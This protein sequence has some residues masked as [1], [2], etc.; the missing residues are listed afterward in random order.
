MRVTGSGDGDPVL[1]QAEVL[2]NQRV[3][4]S[5]AR[6]RRE[7]DRQIAGLVADFDAIRVADLKRVSNSVSG[8]EAATGQRFLEHQNAI[9]QWNQIV[10]NG[11]VVPTSVVR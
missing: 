11:R 6:Q 8:L 4:A 5:E 1:Q 3:A 7:L 2:V 9:S 10:G